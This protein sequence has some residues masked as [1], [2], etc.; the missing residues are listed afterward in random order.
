MTQKRSNVF[1]VGSYCM[2]SN[3]LLEKSKKNCSIAEDLSG[4]RL[5]P[6]MYQHFIDKYVFRNRKIQN[7]SSFTPTFTLLD[8]L[9]C[10]LV[11]NMNSSYI[12]LVEFLA[13]FAVLFFWSRGRLKCDL[14]SKLNRGDK[15]TNVK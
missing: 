13:A 10:K 15:T 7:T 4:F 1:Y 2:S 14:Y 3:D 11:Q 9:T 8:S 5:P 6:P 12:F